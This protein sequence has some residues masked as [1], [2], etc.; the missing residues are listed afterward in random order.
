MEEDTKKPLLILLWIILALM[1]GLLIT[2]YIK[3][4]YDDTSIAYLHVPVTK[5]SYKDKKDL[6]NNLKHT[7]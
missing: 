5:I 4:L 7:L 3:R 1:V 6:N 2:D